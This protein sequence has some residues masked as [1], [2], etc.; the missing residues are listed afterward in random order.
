V[1]AGNVRPR[2]GI[3]FEKLHFGRKLFI[4]HYIF[5]LWSNFQPIK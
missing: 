5:K 1:P 2:P 4:K 3:D